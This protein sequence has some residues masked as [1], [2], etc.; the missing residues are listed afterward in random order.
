MPLLALRAGETVGYRFLIERL[1]KESPMAD[2]T[3]SDLEIMSAAVNYRRWLFEQVADRVGRRVLEVGAGIGNY[4]GFL[5]QAERIVCLE[6]HDE[7]VRRLQARFGTDRRVEVCQ[8][9]IADA[10]LRRLA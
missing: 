1:P 4:T 2:I 5:G 6:I 3:V 10:G 8:G 9:D 7:A